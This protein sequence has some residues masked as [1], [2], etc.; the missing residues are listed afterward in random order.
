[1]DWN[2]KRRVAPT[3]T[4]FANYHQYSTGAIQYV[5]DGSALL[6]G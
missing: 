6:S 3:L 5:A 1:M 4:E 2:W